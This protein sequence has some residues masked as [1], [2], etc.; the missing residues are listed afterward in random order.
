MHILYR[1]LSSAGIGRDNELVDILSEIKIVLYIIKYTMVIKT[2]HDLI[3]A[4]V[5]TTIRDHNYICSDDF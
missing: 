2:Y 3:C 1:Y 4:S 5:L